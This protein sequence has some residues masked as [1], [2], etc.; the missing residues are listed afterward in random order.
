M[1]ATI[2]IHYTVQYV[3][4]C[5]VGTLWYVCVGIWYRMVD[6]GNS[7][8]QALTYSQSE[9][10]EFIETGKLRTNIRQHPSFFVVI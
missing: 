7:F 1:V 4:Y 8:G 10:T 5:T 6:A 3:L 2:A 9:Q